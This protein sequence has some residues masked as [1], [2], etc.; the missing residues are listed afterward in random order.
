[1]AKKTDAKK[2][3]AR[4]IVAAKKWEAFKNILWAVLEDGKL[5]SE[6]EVEAIIKAE[7]SHKVER[8]V[9]L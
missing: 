8:S 9:N 5:Y 4:T 3:D 1:M 6:S 2:M 7:M